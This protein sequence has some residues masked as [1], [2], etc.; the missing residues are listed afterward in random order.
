MG[1][2]NDNKTVS[3]ESDKLTV[4]YTDSKKHLTMPYQSVELDSIQLYGISV[5]ALPKHVETRYAKYN[6]EK[7]TPYQTQLYKEVLCGLAYYSKEELQK[8][9][10]M[11]KTAI[12]IAHIKAKSLLNQWKQSLIVKE[13]DEFLLKLFP[14]SN[15]IKAFVEQTKDYTDESVVP[16][17][18]FEELGISKY[19]IAEKLISVGL[20]PESFFQLKTA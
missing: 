7:F 13:V 10:P 2:K 5:K 15:Q 17:Q 4:Y 18:T 12:R 1:F 6:R 16:S 11:R 14:H 8:L 3:C 9:Q 19:D 20:L